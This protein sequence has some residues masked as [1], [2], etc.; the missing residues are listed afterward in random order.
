LGRSFFATRYRA[1]RSDSDDPTVGVPTVTLG[2]GQMEI[3]TTNERLDLGAFESA[4]R[5]ALRLATG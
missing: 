1:E 2:C 3:H 5:V 4:C